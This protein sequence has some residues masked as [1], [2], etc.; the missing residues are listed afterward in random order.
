MT[1]PEPFLAVEY[2]WSLNVPVIAGVALAGGA[3]AWRLRDL[4]HA[5]APRSGD[6]PAHDSL[7]AL[8]FAGGL[9]VVLLALVSPIDR[10]GEERLFTM[11]MVQHLLLADL[12]PI[13]L[14]LGLSRAF[15]RPA[16]R[17]LRPV[18]ERLGPLA[19]PAVALALYVGLMWLWHL[20]A[21]YELALDHSWAHALEHASFFTAGIAFWWYLIEPVPPRHRLTGPWALAYLGTAKLLMGVLGVILAFAPDALY[22]TYED[23]PRT[24]GLTA[25]EDQNVGGV[26]MMVEQSLV[27]VIAFAVFFSRMLERSESEQRRREA[28]EG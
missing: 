25:V 26:V 22:S 12:A 16:V 27:L 7:R 24:W 11:H 6:S 13:L 10:L 28:M 5:P 8:A 15:L 23:A 21:M 20:P 2:T 18:E 14:L 19:H 1:V 9:A 3:Y 4:R 17:R